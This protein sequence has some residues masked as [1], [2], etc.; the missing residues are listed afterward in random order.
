MTPIHKLFYPFFIFLLVPFSLISACLSDLSLEEKIG[1]LF[2]VHFNGKIANEDAKSLIKELHIGGFIYY[3]WA[4]E[5]SSPQQVFHLSASLQKLAQNTSH[6]IPLWIGIDQEGG[7]VN[8]LKQGFTVFPSQYALGKTDKWEWGKKMAQQMGQELKSVGISLTFGPVVDVYNNLNHP[9][10]GIR[11]F[12]SDPKC[13]SRWGKLFLEGYRQVGILSALK[14]FPGH[15]D[16][17]TDS[18][19]DLPIIHKTRAE[20]ESTELLPF[21]TLCPQ[22]D[23]I[24]SAHLIVPALDPIHCATFSRSIIHDLLRTQWQFK[25][26]IMTDSLVMEGALN[27]CSSIEEAVLKSLQA[28]HDLIL[29]GGKQLNSTQNGKEMRLEDI[30]KIQTFLI[31]AIKKGMIT[32]KDIDEKVHRILELKRQYGLFDFSLPSAFSQIQNQH[33]FA[34]EIAYQALEEIKKDSSL[35][36][37]PSHPH[38]IIAPEYLQEE[39]NQTSW[40]DLMDNGHGTYFKNLNPELEESQQVLACAKKASCHIFFAS[41]L[42]QSE[43]QQRLLEELRKFSSHL[44]VIAIRHPSDLSYVM[45]ADHVLCTYSP[46]V[47]SLQAVYDFFLKS[48]HLKTIENYKITP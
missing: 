3:Q 48:H 32:E 39:L 17:Q 19:D 6:G 37:F 15:G 46:T 40:K 26:V 34:E 20:L 23:L 31:Q 29:L 36:S 14:H 42:A 12:S 1:Q 21:K 47:C 22:A 8:R 33:P 28:G 44:I 27:Q 13:V 38:L 2:I 5:L 30:K 45:Q 43:G 25:G 4:N 18:H 11:S 9:I 24:M 41:H 35:Y 10:I 16:A 7:I